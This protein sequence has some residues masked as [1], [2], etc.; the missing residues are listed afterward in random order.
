M[1]YDSL[2]LLLMW[3]A[4]GIISSILFFSKR[5]ILKGISV[6]ILFGSIYY[7][8]ILTKEWIGRP[9]YEMPETFA[10]KGYDVTTIENTR[11][12]TIWLNDGIDD[13]LARV[14]YD[15]QSENNLKKAMNK[16]KRG[17]PQKGEYKQKN[18]GLLD[19]SPKSPMMFYDF[20]I[21]KVFPKS[22]S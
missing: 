21:Q 22:G 18:K 17:E 14:P 5:N 8:F 11:Y 9:R 6:A 15:E 3:V 12:I 19:N 4:A 20:P 13:L 2:T 7:T 1:I 16:V 10:L